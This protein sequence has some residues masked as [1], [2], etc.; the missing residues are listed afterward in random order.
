MIAG[1]TL[2]KI[3]LLILAVALFSILAFFTFGFQD[4]LSEREADNLI[5]EL[6][7]EFSLHLNSPSLCSENTTTVPD[8]L[9]FFGGKRLF[10]ILTIRK[11]EQTENQNFI[12]LAISKRNEPEK[13]I[14]SG[15]LGT[16]A[17]IK[18]FKADSETSLGISS[19]EEKT[20]VDP[21]AFPPTN[22]LFLVKENFEGEKNFYI[23]PCNSE[24]CDVARSAL[25][26]SVLTDREL[27]N[28]SCFKKSGTVSDVFTEAN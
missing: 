3:N 18:L 11:I 19:A 21:Q 6:K 16:N 14:A 24:Q 15:R 13:T 23:V 28:S 5:D 1:F 2:S 17:N 7:N 20:N 22:A 9:S 12:V 8:N 25:A 26:T 10:Y 4:I 27:E